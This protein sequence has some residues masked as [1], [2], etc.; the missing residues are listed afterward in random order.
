MIANPKVKAKALSVY[1]KEVK[2]STN[3]II[4][5]FISITYSQIMGA[6]FV[7]VWNPNVFVN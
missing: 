2:G 7:G 1:R 6:D 5:S 3:L 4:Y